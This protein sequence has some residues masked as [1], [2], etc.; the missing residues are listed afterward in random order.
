MPEIIFV[1]NNGSE[2]RVNAEVGQS[3]MQVALD[4]MLPGIIGDC[5]GSG[6]CATCHGYIDERW[7]SDIAPPSEDELMMLECAIEP[8]EN[9]RLTCQ[10][11]VTDEMEGLTVSL[12]VSQY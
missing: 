2:H 8:A 10:V 11:M 4:N 3:L 5:G 12:P 7:F 1:E 6:S 9:S